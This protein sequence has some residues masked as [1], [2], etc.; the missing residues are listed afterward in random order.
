MRRDGS[1]SARHRVLLALFVA[2]TTIAVACASSRP[3]EEATHH[4]SGG[5]LVHRFERAEAWAQ[6]FDDP[7]RDGWQRP[8]DVVAAMRIEPGM[9]VAD[10]GAAT[11]YFEPWLS[12]AVGAAGTVLALDVEPDMVRYLGERARRENLANVR[13]VLVARDD[14]RLPVGGV[15]RILVVNTWHHIASREAYSTRLR[16][17]LKPGGRVFVV[18]FTRDAG[19]G[20]PAHHRLS[21]EQVA[22]ELAAGG[23]A[24]EVLEISLPD[25]YVVVGTRRPR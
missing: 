16:D 21:P 11:G 23:L 15:D 4:A 17:A 24:A 5:P 1:R 14:P 25:Q 19:R 12:R 6:Q 8:A 2:L 9:V 22:R 13:P 20:P 3:H 7:S 10:I 18:D